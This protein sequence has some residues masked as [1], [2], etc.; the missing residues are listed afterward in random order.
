MF[1]FFTKTWALFFGFA[2]ISLAH[3]LQGTLLGVR[4]VFE[5]F[6]YISIGVVVAGYYVGFLC[7]SIV[8]P[9]LLGRVG[10]IRVFAALASLASIAILLH[11][12]FLDPFSWFIIRILTGISLSGIF[13][14][15]ES[16]INDKSTNQ[17][18]GQMLSIYMII[19]FTF[20]GLGQFLLNLSEPAKVDLFIL[21]SILLSFSLLPI[22]LSISEAPSISPTKRFTF[23]ELYAISPLG[24]FG[25]IFTGLAHSAIF[26]YGAVYATAKELSLFE[27][28]L[29]MV[30]VT[31]FGALF[32][33]PIGYF[34]DRFDRRIILT[35]VTFV[36]AGLSIF[37][38]A[39][40]Y[41]SL[42]LFFILLAIYSGMSLPMYSLVIAHTND[43]LQPHEIVPASSA[44]AILV[45][46]GAICGPILSSTFMK[47]LGA[48]GFFVYIFIVHGLLGLFGLYRMAK[49]AKPSDVESQYVPLPR[50]ISPAGMEL[51]P[52]AEPLDE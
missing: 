52:K 29:F 42:I 7:G 21:V 37:I 10:H 18:R 6:S 17:T 16:W 36:A 38:V 8:I 44:I 39:S 35:S 9:I 30:I 3:G 13:I 15:M 12:V 23:V 46:I 22:L 34:S 25:A 5:G 43:Y 24:F 47:A 41:F 48:D 2:I 26:G 45:G 50:N 19:T 27:I 4:A 51:N 31:S 28:S 32:Q 11:S 14:I 40:S 1:T 20:L 33:W 49:R